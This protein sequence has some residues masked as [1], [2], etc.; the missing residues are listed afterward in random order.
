VS[1]GIHVAIRGI[2]TRIQT[3]H[4]KSPKLTANSQKSGFE[5]WDFEFS[6]NS[7]NLPVINDWLNAIAGTWWNWWI[8]P[9]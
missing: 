6:R 4:A 5:I 8:E 7:I 9:I 2:V 1:D 3:D